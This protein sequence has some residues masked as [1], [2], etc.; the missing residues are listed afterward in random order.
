[1]YGFFDDPVNIYLILES[2]SGGHLYKQLK[3]HQSMPE[4][5]VA[6]IMRQVCNAV[7]ELHSHR[8]IHRDIKPENIVLQDVYSSLFRM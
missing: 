7:N 2:A 3:K 8:I 1:M 6:A 5:K 4:I